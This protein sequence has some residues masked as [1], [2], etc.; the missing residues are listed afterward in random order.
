[1]DIYSKDVIFH[2]SW[3]D[4]YLISCLEKVKDRILIVLAILFGNVYV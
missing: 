4:F 3:V 2:N 1:M